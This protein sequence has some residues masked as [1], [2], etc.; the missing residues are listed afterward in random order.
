MKNN[1][2]VKECLNNLDVKECPNDSFNKY[3]TKFQLQ[4]FI[5][6]SFIFSVYTSI[7]F[8][9]KIFYYVICEGNWHAKNNIK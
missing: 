1:L 4:R 6:Y 2:D 9:I 8:V 5:V 7:L 3:K